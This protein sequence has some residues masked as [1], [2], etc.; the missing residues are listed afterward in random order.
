[1]ENARK[2]LCWHRLRYADLRSRRRGD[3]AASVAGKL[4][5]LIAFLVASTTSVPSSSR[6]PKIDRERGEGGSLPFLR[7]RSALRSRYRSRPAYRRLILDLR[8]SAA[9]DEAADILRKRVPAESLPWLNALLADEDYN[10]LSN[11]ARS[12][13]PDEMVEMRMLQETLAWIRRKEAATDLEAAGAGAETSS[14]PRFRK[15]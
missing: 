14:I 12:G 4:F 8:R 6:G 15:P 11:V 7:P 9:H 1:M 2:R 5:A 13:V 3:P 10:A